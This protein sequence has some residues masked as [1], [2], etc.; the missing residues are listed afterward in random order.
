MTAAPTVTPPV[1]PGTHLLGRGRG[2]NVFVER[3]RYFTWDAAATALN[4]SSQTGPQLV[5][6]N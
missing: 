1:H 5:V 3:R 4:I 6:R 2:A